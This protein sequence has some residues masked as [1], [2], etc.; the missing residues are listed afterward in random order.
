MGEKKGK[1]NTQVSDRPE[2]RTAFMLQTRVTIK[3]PAVVYIYGYG[4]TP[5]SGAVVSLRGRPAPH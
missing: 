4:S 5:D 3:P 2:I 1:K